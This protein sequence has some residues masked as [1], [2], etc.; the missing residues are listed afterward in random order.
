LSRWVRSSCGSW[1]W[2]SGGIYRLE[3]P[4]S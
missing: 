1:S 4:P 2:W 3:S